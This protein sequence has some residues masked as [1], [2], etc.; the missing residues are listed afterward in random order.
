M[1][2]DMSNTPD[3]LQDA[4]PG[5]WVD[6]LAPASTRPYLRLSRLDRPI[7]SWLLL[8]PCWWSITLAAPPGSGPDIWLFIL[9]G[10]GALV[11]RGAGCTF[12]DIV[13]RNYDDKVAR[14]RLRPLPSGAVTLTRAI[15]WLGIQGLIGLT[16]LLALND[17]SIGLGFFSLILVAIYPFMKR[18]TWWPQFFLGLAFNWGAVMGYAAA[19]GR[20]D[21]APLVLYA[22]GIAWTLGYDT[23]YALQDREDDA[24]IGVRSTA[25][26]FGAQ[27]RPWLAGFYGLAI[28]AFAL[29]GFLAGLSWPYAVALICVALHFLWQIATLRI[30]DP[31]DCLRKFRSNRDLGLILLIG[32]L[33]GRWIIV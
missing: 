19:A 20:I 13:D 27:T 25:R 5:N 12:N 14:T 31:A 33:L 17:L 23:I 29:S 22:G 24:L 18:I 10:L 15:L 6:R 4:P 9:F 8:L 3:K 26:L 7:G 2:R 21:P 28:S 30:D 16:V 11:M 32:L 1:N